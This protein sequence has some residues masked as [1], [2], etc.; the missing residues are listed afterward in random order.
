MQDVIIDEIDCSL[1][2][3]PSKNCNFMGFKS[4]QKSKTSGFLKNPRFP[5]KNIKIEKPF[6]SVLWS[7]SQISKS[8][9]TKSNCHLLT[10][11]KP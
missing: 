7:R 1:N 11:E 10:I 4:P 5:I 2:L 3:F 9:S 6:L 8:R